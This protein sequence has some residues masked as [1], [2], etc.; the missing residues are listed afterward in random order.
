M[1][2]GVHGTSSRK[3]LHVYALLFFVFFFP[4]SLQREQA[5]KIMLIGEGRD[6][7]TVP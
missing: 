7:F 1:E 3:V 5:S 6:V 4:S 2:L